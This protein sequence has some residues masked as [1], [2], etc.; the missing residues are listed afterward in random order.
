MPVTT[1]T[2]CCWIVVNADGSPVDDDCESHHTTE[3]EAIKEAANLRYVGE[4][5]PVVKQLDHLCSSAVTVCGY[6]Y[7]EDDEGAQHWP[8]RAEAFQDWLVKHA[9]YRIGE[10]GELLC[11]LNHGCDECNAVPQVVTPVEL[12]GQMT[13]GEVNA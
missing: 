13:L 6:V 10:N 5:A 11:P 1:A 9:D 3:A 7:D 8:D 12:P 4:S 2:E